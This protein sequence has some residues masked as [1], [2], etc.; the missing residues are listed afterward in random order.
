MNNK[1]WIGGLIGASI[2]A[3]GL[4]LS[5]TQAESIISIVCSIIGLLFTIT[6]YVIK[7]IKWYQNAKKDGKIDEEE[8]DDLSHIIEDGKNEIDKH[9]QDK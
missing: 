1:G 3:M 7:I 8:L 2:S 4:P 6:W 5:T 9:N